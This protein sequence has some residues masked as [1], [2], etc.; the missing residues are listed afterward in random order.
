L[1][2]IQPAELREKFSWNYGIAGFFN[3]ITREDKEKLK[4]FLDSQSAHTRNSGD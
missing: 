3:F 1:K 2:E 4:T